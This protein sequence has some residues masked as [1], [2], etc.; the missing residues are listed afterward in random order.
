MYWPLKYAHLALALLSIT[1]FLL[2]G[3]WMMRGSALLD[4]R[5]TRTVPH[6]VDTLFLLSGVALVL[7]LSLPVMQSPWLLAKFAGLVVYVVLGSIALRRGPT[8][9]LRQIAFVGALSAFAYI[10]GAAVSK[11]PASWLTAVLQTS[12]FF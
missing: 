4:H 1:G 8:L 6:V 11:S 12:G 5:A 10:V 3:F 9:A 2:R 7:T